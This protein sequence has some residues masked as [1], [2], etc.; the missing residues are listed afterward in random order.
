MHWRV[1]PRLGF[2]LQRGNTSPSDARA[3]LL[4][5]HTYMQAKFGEGGSLGRRRA[6]CGAV[7]DLGVG[8]QE[9]GGRRWKTQCR[10]WGGGM[11][12]YLYSGRSVY[13]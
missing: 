11:R 7:L 4:S 2:S 3:R 8:C 13:G 9:S 6:A 10:S 1:G 12:V 5:R